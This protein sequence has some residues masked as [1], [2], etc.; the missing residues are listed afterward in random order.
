MAGYKKII[1]KYNIFSNYCARKD[2]CA[3]Q[4][5]EVVA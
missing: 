3:E 2:T 5:G 4:K 1:N